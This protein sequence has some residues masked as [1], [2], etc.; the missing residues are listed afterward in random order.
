MADEK[1]ADAEQTATHSVAISDGTAF[2]FTNA[3]D[4]ATA[5]KAISEQFKTALTEG[6]ALAAALAAEIAELCEK[7]NMPIASG[8]IRAGKSLD[9]VRAEIQSTRVVEDEKTQIHSAVLSET[10]ADA[11]RKPGAAPININDSPLVKMADAENARHVAA[12][13]GK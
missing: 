7:A 3:A 12:R 6:K 2:E 13:K 8:L 11:S 1:P 9:E 5:A 10:G 4:A